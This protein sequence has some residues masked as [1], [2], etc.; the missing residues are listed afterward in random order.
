MQDSF[1]A[2]GFD[3]FIKGVFAGDVWDDHNVENVPS[4]V[5]VS[6]ADL[7]CLLL[8]SD[9]GNNLM[10]GFEKLLQDMGWSMSVRPRSR[11]ETSF[12]TSRRSSSEFGG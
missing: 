4:E 10:A 1:Q 9:C 6:I 2:R 5:L 3:H 11:H 7:L 12:V 8:G